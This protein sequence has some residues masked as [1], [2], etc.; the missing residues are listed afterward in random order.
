MYEDLVRKH[1]LFIKEI[2]EK[3]MWAA[4]FGVMLVVIFILHLKIKGEFPPQV[5]VHSPWE[6]YKITN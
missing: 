1:D 6:S 2:Y 3:W 4:V 5:K